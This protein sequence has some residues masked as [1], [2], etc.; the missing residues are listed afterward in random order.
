MF[1]EW[2]AMILN[3]FD[4]TLDMLVQ[5]CELFWNCW[6]LDMLVQRGLCYVLFASWMYMI[7]LWSGSFGSLFDGLN[8][9]K[10]LI[11]WLS[12][13]LIEM[14]ERKTDWN[15]WQKDW[16]TEYFIN[17][18]WRKKCFDIEKMILKGLIWNKWFRK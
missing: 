4:W 6:T 5:G 12:E 16:P 17:S 18:F 13:K 14:F 3:C 10:W 15:D 7:D 1:Y 11:E 8:V 9:L 2:N